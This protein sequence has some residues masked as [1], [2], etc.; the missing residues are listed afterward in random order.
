VNGVILLT[1]Y[2][3]AERRGLI[4]AD[5]S[6]DECMA[7]ATLYQMS[8]SLRR[9][10]ATILLFYES[11]DVCGLWNRHL[12]AMSEDYRR[13]IQSTSVVEQMVLID[14]RNLLH[15]MSKDIKSFPLPDIN[16][17]YDAANGIPREIFEESSIYPNADDVALE[18][19]HNNEQRAAFDEIISVIDSAEGRVFF[20]DG[21]GGTGKTYLYK[22]LLAKIHSQNKIVVATATSGIEASILPGGRTA[23][24]RFKIPLTIEDGT[25]YSFTKLL[26]Q[27]WI[28]KHKGLIPNLISKACQSI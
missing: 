15:S 27:K 11:N 19:S 23:H 16:D 24:S 5:N 14:I 22:A 6:L 20:V 2:E 28:C 25:F 18:G 13:N 1:F 21:P 4:E 17:T 10:F 9:L 3:A 26:M 8:S 12:D 7:E